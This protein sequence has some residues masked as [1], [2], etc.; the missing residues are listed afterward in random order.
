MPNNNPNPPTDG[1]PEPNLLKKSANPAYTHIQGTAESMVANLSPD[2]IAGQ[3]ENATTVVTWMREL[4]NKDRDQIDVTNMWATYIA[5]LDSITPR[6]DQHQNLV[7]ARDAQGNILGNSN[8][9]VTLAYLTSVLNPHGKLPAVIDRILDDYT[10]LAHTTFQR[11]Y[12]DALRPPQVNPW[13]ARKAPLGGVSNAPT[14][15]K[16]VWTIV[17]P[18]TI[19]AELPEFLSGRTGTGSG[20]YGQSVTPM[21]LIPT[22]RGPDSKKKDVSENPPPAASPPSDANSTTKTDNSG[23]ATD[24]HPARQTADDNKSNNDAKGRGNSPTSAPETG[25]G[26]PSDSGS[27]SIVQTSSGSIESTTKGSTTTNVAK[28]K[29]GNVVDTWVTKKP[30]YPD[31]DGDGSGGSNPRASGYRPYDDGGGSGGGVGGP[32][33]YN[34]F[35]DPESTGGGSPRS[36]GPNVMPNPDDAVGPR[37]PSA[38]VGRATPLR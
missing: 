17:A 4:P 34:F 35:P 9:W 14:W 7:P 33:G 11:E 31:P 21:G 3:L 20:Q 5:H 10:A 37:G 29:D 6:V 36:R 18:S 19:G 13:T 16:R 22:R 12:G 2:A 25:G 28:D 24:A 15:L 26:Q 23:Q 27:K 30:N 1:A 8:P 38:R 32:R